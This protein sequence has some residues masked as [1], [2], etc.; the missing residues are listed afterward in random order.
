[1]PLITKDDFSNT[2]IPLFEEIKKESRTIKKIELLKNYKYRN[3]LV[4]ILRYAY[5][6][7]ILFNVTSKNV[8]MGR[9]GIMRDLSLSIF[10]KLLNMSHSEKLSFLKNG[11]SWYNEKV[12][13]YVG[14]ILDKDLGIGIN[15]KTINSALPDT[16]REFQVMLAY[17]QTEDK[18]NL[19]FGKLPWCYYNLKIDGVRCRIDVIDKEHVNFYSRN[20]KE[21]E[22]FLVDNIRG[23]II[24]N[25]DL[26]EGSKLDCEIACDNFQKFMKI[27]RRKSF[28]NM[29]TIRIRNSVRLFIFDEISQPDRTLEDRVSK[30]E[31]MEYIM[32][33][34]K[35]LFIKFLKYEKINID[36]MKIGEMA[37]SFIRQGEEGIIIKNP[38]AHYQFK[39]SNDWLKFKNKDTIDCLIT[40]YYK[41]EDGTK[42]ENTLGGIILDYNGKELKCGSGFTDEERDKIWKMKDEIVNT[43]CEISYM[44]ETRDG[45]LRHPVFEKFRFDLDE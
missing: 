42:Y 6:P 26:F 20:G 36:Y 35:S 43:H 23:E 27:Y 16:I 13:E 29:D 25:I 22:E 33:K 32:S 38:W 37:R 2:I 31:R 24:R 7:N 1:M 10:E 34:R 19:T 3:E 30:L 17:K 4:Q 28:A 44:E 5:D 21:M 15:I 45:S 40:G 39:R 18:F 14:R 11:L 12:R 8:P 9:S 41:G